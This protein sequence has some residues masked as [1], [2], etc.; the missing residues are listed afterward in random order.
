MITV[1]ELEKLYREDMLTDAQIGKIFGMTQNSISKLR[2]KCGIPTFSRA[3][4]FAASN[5][6]PS[7]FQKQILYGTALG[8][9]FITKS[10][11][12]GSRRQSI[13]EIKHSIDTYDQSEY[14]KW[15]FSCLSNLFHKPKKCDGGKK[16]RI[17][18]Y[19]SSFFTEMR[20]ELYD[21]SG[22][23]RVSRDLLDK[24]DPLALAVWYMDDGSV[25]S[26]GSAC[27]LC[28]HNFTLREN[29]IIAEWL[30]DKYDID[31]KIQKDSKYFYLR[32]NKDGAAKL[33]RVIDKYIIESM[34]YKIGDKENNKIAY[35]CGPMEYADDNGDEWRREYAS[36]LL[37]LNIRSIVPNNEEKKIKGIYSMNELKKS[38][39]GKYIQIMREFIRMDLTFVEAADVIITR[40]EGEAS[41]G[42]IHEA[43]KAYELGKP[44]YLI[45]SRSDKEVLGWFL[46]CFTKIFNSLDELVEYLK[47]ERREE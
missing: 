19:A 27:K 1:K 2:K 23:K 10:N 9:A 12:R 22:V 13:M 28:T 16:L 45:T 21:S 46:A 29:K 31:S 47:D 20:S 36:K 5:V 39:I 44:C 17:R 33:W 34:W 40:W 37:E 38:N 32:F 26:R 24:L 6:F 15:I 42:T 18:S 4:R 14:V 3:E 43:G 11:D 41:A 35:L 25:Q 7:D 8:D 30:K